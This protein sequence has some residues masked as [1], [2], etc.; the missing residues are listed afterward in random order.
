M[1]WEE[2]DDTELQTNLD[3]LLEKQKE[4]VSQLRP[5]ENLI[6]NTRKI[7]TKTEISSVV[8]KGKKIDNVIKIK[9]K[10]K[11]DDDMTDEYRLTTKDECV[12]KTNELLN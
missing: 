9:P 2:T 5:I 7:Q 12:T 6:D 10:D 3:R 8:E 11:W 1:V 4:L